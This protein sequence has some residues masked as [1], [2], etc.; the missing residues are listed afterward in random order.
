MRPLTWK[1][2]QDPCMTESALDRSSYLLIHTAGEEAAIHDKY[3]A[4]DKTC[5]IRSQKHG[6]AHQFVELAESSHRS[7][8]KELASASGSFKQ[9]CIQICEEHTGS[10][11]VHT[12][13]IL[14]PFNSQRSGQGRD[15]SFTRGVCSYIV[16][17]NK[18]RERSDINDAA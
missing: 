15:R 4:G 11:R 17:G 3:M 9:R 14:R 12:Y 7:A 1:W 10:N 18:R 8:D 16:Q 13:T 2:V 6:R 5:R